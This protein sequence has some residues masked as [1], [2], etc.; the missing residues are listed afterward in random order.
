MHMVGGGNRGI[1]MDGVVVGHTMIILTKVK[2]GQLDQ[3]RLQ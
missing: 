3:N 1:R 2:P